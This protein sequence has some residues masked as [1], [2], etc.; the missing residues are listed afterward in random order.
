[1]IRHKIPTPTPTYELVIVSEFT[2][3]EAAVN[4]L[5]KAKLNK[6]APIGTA[7]DR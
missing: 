7:K 3:G 6:I 4:R 5:S 1:M 2:V